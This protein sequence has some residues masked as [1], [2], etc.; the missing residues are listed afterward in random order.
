M[1]MV[2]GQHYMLH[3]LIWF[4]VTGRWPKHQVDHRDRCKAN[5]AWSNLRLAT[6]KQNQENVGLRKDN[7]SGHRGVWWRPEVGKW[8]ALI[9]HNGHL[10]HLGHFAKKKDAIRARR[11]AEQQLFTHA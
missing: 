8:R 9:R 1:V 10:H 11:E 4:Y 2:F 6:N 5:N 3:T 7:V